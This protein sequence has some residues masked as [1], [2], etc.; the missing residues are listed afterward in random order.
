METRQYARQADGAVMAAYG[1][2]ADRGCAPPSCLEKQPKPGLDFFPLTVKT[3]QEKTFAA[4][5][6][7]AALQREGRPSEKEMLTSA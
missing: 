6:F 5:R 7:R 2:A 1:R 3:Y 4:A